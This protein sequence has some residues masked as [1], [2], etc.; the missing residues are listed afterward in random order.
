MAI[1]PWELRHLNPHVCD[2]C[3]EREAALYAWGTKLVRGEPILHCWFVC[4]Q[5]KPARPTW[6]T[7]LTWKPLVAGQV[8]RRECAI[9]AAP[10]MIAAINLMASQIT[11][12]TD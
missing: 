12:E 9:G 4:R 8:P 10:R 11:Q 3:S 5:C 6:M 2:I 7:S 1:S